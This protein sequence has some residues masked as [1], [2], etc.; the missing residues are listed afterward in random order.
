M[1]SF[2][3]SNPKKKQINKVIIEIL[4]KHEN[5]EIECSIC[6]SNHT[7]DTCILTDCKHVFG[8][9]CFDKWMNIN[10]N[11]LCPLCRNKCENNIT[12]F[13]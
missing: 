1:N 11:A 10:K 3:I 9:T 13:C 5:I 12:Y 6:L 8:T 7:K 2:T 4:S